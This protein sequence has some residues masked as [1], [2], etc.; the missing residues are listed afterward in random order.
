ME[1]NTQLNDSLTRVD[2]IING[3]MLGDSPTRVSDIN[4]IFGNP[5][6]ANSVVYS[7]ENVAIKISSLIQSQKREMML[8][9][10]IRN[11]IRKTNF[12]EL[13][14]HLEDGDISEEEFYKILN[15]DSHRYEI[16]LKNLKSN[17]DVSIIIDL[18][19]KIGHD[20]RELSTSEVAEMFS[21]KETELLPTVKQIFNSQK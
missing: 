6:A 14:E 19:D 18:I 15:E 16:T 1:K 3:N 10:A 20:L 11:N 8:I 2:W 4:I 5:T 9:E 12:I 17:E 7:W 13:N 21:I